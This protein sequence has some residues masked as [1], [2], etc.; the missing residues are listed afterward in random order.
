MNVSINTLMWMVINK[1]DLNNHCTM[2]SV[3]ASCIFC[4]KTV[5][6]RHQAINCDDCGGWQ[7]R[8]CG[9][10]GMYN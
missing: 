1:F 7:H 6:S 9:N 2:S 10:I 4:S 5:K 3:S 8:G